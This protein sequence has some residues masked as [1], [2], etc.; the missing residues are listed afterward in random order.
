M[1]TASSMTSQGLALA[2]GV[3]PA[4]SFARQAPIG[5]MYRGAT[6][7]R[8]GQMPFNLRGPEL[9]VLFFF[10]A[11]IVGV[12]LLIVFL[13]KAASRPSA[14]P[15][16]TIAP[17]PPGWYPVPDGSGRVAWWDGSQWDESMTPPNAPG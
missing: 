5:L 8:G 7:P 10:V 6:Q 1:P 12:I 9:L 3:S 4:E 2:V 14:P 17:Q 13:V 11:I 16:T 15:A